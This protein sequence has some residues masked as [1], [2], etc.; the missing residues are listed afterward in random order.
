MVNVNDFYGLCDNDIIENAINNR[1]ADGT[2]LITPR[3]CDFDTERD[4]WLLD[5]AIILPE[6]TT[7]LLRNVKLKLSDKCRDNFFRSANCESIQEK[8][9]KKIK[10]IHIIGEGMCILEGADHPRASGCGGKMQHSPC[11]HLPEDL[12]KYGDWLSDEH[13][14]SPEN[15]DFFDIHNHSYGTDAGKEVT[16]NLESWRVFGIFFA[17]VENFTISGLNMIDFHCFA[18]DIEACSF[19]RIEKINYSANMSK[20]IDGM[21]MH[22]ENQDGLHICWGCHNITVSD[23]TGQTGDDVVA[24]QDCGFYNY[25]NSEKDIHDITIKNVTARSTICCVVRLLAVRAKIYNVIIDKIID[26]LPDYNMM[27]NA[28]ILIGDNGYYGKENPNG[29]SSISISNIICNSHYA[30]NVQGYM[31][32]SVISNVIN[33]NP[34]CPVFYVRHSENVENVTTTNLI[35]VSNK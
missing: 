6:N 30:I 7:I 14:S 1:D 5:R 2:V 19:G 27:S 35:T 31:K 33:K 13:R 17:N 3:K 23:I 20:E 18:I 24:L 26:T 8:E 25:D 22:I 4:Y 11:P 15:I 34:T 12:C 10:N 9:P 29:I 28:T 21:L 32:N 16:T